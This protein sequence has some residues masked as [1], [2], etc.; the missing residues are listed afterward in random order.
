MKNGEN[1]SFVF[2]NPTKEREQKLSHLTC[3]ST[4]N[5][6]LALGSVEGRNLPTSGLRR[7]GCRHQGGNQVEE[8]L[9]LSSPGERLEEMQRWPLGWEGGLSTK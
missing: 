7:T 4:L 1:W 3:P 2:L 5:V 9:R 8:Q 6:E